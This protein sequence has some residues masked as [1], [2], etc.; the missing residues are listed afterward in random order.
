MKGQIPPLT[1]VIIYVYVDCFEN[2]WSQ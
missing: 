2:Y 1:S